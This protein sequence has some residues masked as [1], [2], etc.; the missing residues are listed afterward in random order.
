M[1][2]EVVICLI[3]VAL[4][5]IG[6]NTTQ[7]FSSDTIVEITSQLNELKDILNQDEMQTDNEQAK[8]KID[9]ISE[10]WKEKYKTLAYYIEHNE[11]EKI[12]TNLVGIKSYI[13]SNELPEALEELDTAS[14]I[15]SHIEEKYAFNLQNIF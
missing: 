10:V 4:I 6:N 14:F 7:S 1:W 9:E 2:K 11:L 13:E 8:I 15:L 12:E 3:I 5:V